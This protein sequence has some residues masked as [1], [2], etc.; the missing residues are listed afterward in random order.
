MPRLAGVQPAGLHIKPHKRGADML[1][2]IDHLTV[3]Y[4]DR[5]V[6][7]DFNLEMNEGE[8]VCLV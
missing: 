2:K 3:A 8:V 6:V 7:K 4:G 5:P 1:L